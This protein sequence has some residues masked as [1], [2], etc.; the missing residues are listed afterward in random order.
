MSRSRSWVLIV[1]GLTA[2]LAG[3]RSVGA[4]TEKLA[5]SQDNAGAPKHSRMLPPPLRT[6]LRELAQRP[7]SFRPLTIFSEADTPSLM[8]GY[9]LLDAKH[10]EPNVFT[11][12][13]PSI[14]SGVVPTAIGAESR[15]ADDR[16]R[17][18]RRR[19]EAWPADGSERRG[20][21]H[22]HVHGHLRALRDQQRVRLVRGLADP[23]SRG[24]GCRRA[25]R[26]WSCDVR[27]DHGGRR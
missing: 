1:A 27:D 23:R 6:R 17:P 7:H 22:R 24:S 18:D 3:G 14:N 16:L 10:F 2:V 19:A 12:I 11:T 9:Y 26:G 15:P 25:T 21:V 5:Q 20:R 13:I 4:A 8:F